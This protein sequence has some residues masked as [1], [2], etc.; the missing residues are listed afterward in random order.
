MVL[1]PMG[2]LYEIDDACVAHKLTS[3]KGER[4]YKEDGMRVWY[5]WAKTDTII[6]GEDY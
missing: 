4:I 2:D 5:A 3:C 6:L 1:I